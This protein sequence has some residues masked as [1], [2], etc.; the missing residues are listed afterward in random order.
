MIYMVLSKGVI[1]LHGFQTVKA[2]AGDSVASGSV[3]F[4]LSVSVDMAPAVQ[5]QVHSSVPPSENV[6][7]A[8]VPFDT[9]M[10]FQNQVLYDVAIFQFGNVGVCPAAC[11]SVF[12][13]SL[14]FSPGK[15]SDGSLLPQCCRSEPTDHG[16]R[17]TSERL[18][19]NV[20]FYSTVGRKDGRK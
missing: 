14:Q 1:V 17:E 12:Q 18:L 10:C 2:K 6:V 3:T 20:N 4:Q 16:A 5:I 9:D 11:W 15:R 7:A 13:V 19:L 8:S